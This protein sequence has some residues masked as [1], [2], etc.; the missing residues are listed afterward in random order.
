MD[1]EKMHQQLEEQHERTTKYWEWMISE[2]PCAPPLDDI[3]LA[4]QN[5]MQAEREV[6]NQLKRGDLV[7]SEKA[8]SAAGRLENKA[9]HMISHNLLQQILD[10]V[11]RLDGKRNP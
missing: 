5:L 11:R 8:M 6:L 10:G 3:R 7:L 2:G 4:V 9:Y 1:I